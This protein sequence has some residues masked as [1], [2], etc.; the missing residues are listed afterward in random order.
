MFSSNDI[1]NVEFEEVKRGYNQTDVKAFLRKV[2]EQIEEM[3][4][5]DS[6]IEAERAAFTSEK[7][8]LEEKM[9]VLADRV[10]QYRKEEDSLR[11]A[12]L[13][14]QKLGDTIVK[15]ANENAEIILNDAR[16]KAEE[17]VNSAS[18]N[19]ENEKETLEKMQAE[20]SKFKNDVLN[21]YKTHLEV[22]SMIPEVTSEKEAAR[23]SVVVENVEPVKS[24]PVAEVKVPE[25]QP[26]EQTVVVEETQVFEPAKQEIPAEAPPAAV[27]AEPTPQPEPAAQPQVTE[28]DD[29]FYAPAVPEAESNPF[30]TFEPMP[31][32]Q[33]QTPEQIAEE[34]KSEDAAVLPDATNSEEAPSR[35]GALDFGDGFSFNSK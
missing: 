32:I 16:K 19:I 17:I 25:P 35:F 4:K 2:S 30:A 12:L 18:G 5:A 11:T 1:R 34:I 10:E 24:E 14:A 6:G 15:E 28:I 21:I 9:L 20:V 8:A 7:A 13:N 27:T 3:E 22:L 26:E 29:A 31:N 33:Q 23:E